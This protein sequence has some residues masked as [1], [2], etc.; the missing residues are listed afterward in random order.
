MKRSLP[1]SAKLSPI[2]ATFVVILGGAKV[3]DKIEVVEN[4]MRI[5]DAMLIGGGMAY[6]FSK[7]KA[8]PWQVS[9]GRRQARTCQASSHGSQQKKFALSSPL[10]TSSARIQ[11]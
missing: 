6:T 10:I 5:A 1:I 8:S 11:S 2:F 7:P 3:S 4:L 9:R